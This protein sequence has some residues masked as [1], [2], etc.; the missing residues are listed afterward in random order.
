MRGR[1][2]DE[3]GGVVAFTGWLELLEALA[4]LLPIDRVVGPPPRRFGGNRRP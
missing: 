2:E 4:E 1:V 3:L